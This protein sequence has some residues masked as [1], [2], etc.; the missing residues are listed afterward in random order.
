VGDSDQFV[1]SGGVIGFVISNETVRFVINL[2]AMERSGLRISS[3]MLS[4]A[5]RFY[6]GEGPE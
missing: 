2:N 3:R 5:V 6:G 1:R 4:L